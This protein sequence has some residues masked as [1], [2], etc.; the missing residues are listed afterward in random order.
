MIGE[1]KLK[2]LI[3]EVDEL[4]MYY[5]DDVYEA[6]AD[7]FEKDFYPV[8]DLLETLGEWDLALFLRTLDIQLFKMLYRLAEHTRVIRGAI[9]DYDLYPHQRS[10]KDWSN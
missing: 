3:I 1:R 4:F 2:D 8:I 9:D 5:D 10:L 7:D 6:I